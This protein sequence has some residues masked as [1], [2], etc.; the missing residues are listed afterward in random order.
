MLYHTLLRTA[1][2]ARYAVGDVYD[3]TLEKTHGRRMVTA[4]T[5]LIPAPRRMKGSAATGSRATDGFAEGKAGKERAQHRRRQLHGE[6]ELALRALGVRELARS[7]RLAG[8]LL[9]VQEEGV[10]LLQ[11]RVQPRGRRRVAARSRGKA[12]SPG[13]RAR[14]L[15]RRRR[16][17]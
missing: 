15:V 8:L 4:R 3:L 5:R 11:P 14:R 16:G 13:R 6:P 7:V 2:F 1:D 9:R 17:R 12:P 10:L